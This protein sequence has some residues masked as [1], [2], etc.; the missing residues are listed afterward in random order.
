[1]KKSELLW[2]IGLWLLGF[3]GLA[4]IAGIFK[5]LLLLAY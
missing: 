4:V 2:F 5:G 1:M 3:L